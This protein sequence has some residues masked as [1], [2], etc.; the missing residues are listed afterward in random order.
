MLF[1]EARH[2]MDAKNRLFIPANQR[3]ELGETFMAVPSFRD[4]CI[5][6][7]SMEE[8]KK[9]YDNIKAKLADNGRRLAEINRF[10]HHSAAQLTPDAQGRVVLTAKLVAHAGISKNVV[11]IGCGDYAEIWS[12]TNYAKIK[13]EDTPDKMRMELARIGL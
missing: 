7:Y 1:G 5:N 13:Q 11:I 9:Y 8:W 3:D 12:E 2:N 4:K 6:L 10:L